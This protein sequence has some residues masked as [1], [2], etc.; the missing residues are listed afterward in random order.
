[1]FHVCKY[2]RSQKFC[3]LRSIAGCPEA[4]IKNIYNAVKCGVTH[5]CTGIIVCD[6]SGKGHFNSHVFSWPAYMLNLGLSW[7]SNCHQVI[8]VKENMDHVMLRSVNETC[9]VLKEW[10]VQ[11]E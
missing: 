10:R 11:C 9:F 4:A 3:F 5:G 1:M 2:R 6:W 7:N 8:E